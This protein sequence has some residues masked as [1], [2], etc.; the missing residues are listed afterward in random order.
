MMNEGSVLSSKLEVDD[1]GYNHLVETAKWAKFL[2]IVGIILSS[3]LVLIALFAGTFMSMFIPNS[4]GQAGG[5]AMLSVVYIIIAA[6]YFLTS[7][8]LYRFG[9]KM[10]NAL[11]SNDQ[12]LFNV[13]LSNQRMF[14]RIIGIIMIIYLVIIVLAIVVALLAVRSTM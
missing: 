13:A 1:L 10:Q 4:E 7:L 3:L 6:I 11:N 8:Y 12:E 9:V 2:A 14:Y 5:A